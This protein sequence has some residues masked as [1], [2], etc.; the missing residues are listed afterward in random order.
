MI[1][2]AFL[3]DVLSKI[4]V[5]EQ[6]VYIITTRENVYGYLLREG[7]EP[8]LRHFIGMALGHIFGGSKITFH[9]KDGCCYFSSQSGDAVRLRYI[10]VNDLLCHAKEC[11]A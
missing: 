7:R 8:Y 2:D 1:D 11:T 6:H 10:E 9:V 3:D 4:H 5:K